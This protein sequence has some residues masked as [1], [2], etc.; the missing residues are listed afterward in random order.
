MYRALF[1]YDGQQGDRTLTFKSGDEFNLI[2]QINEHWW[3]MQSSTGE[4][5]LVPST[6]LAINK[7]V[8]SEIIESIERAI[9][10][11]HKSAAKRGGPLTA[12]ER[13]SL[14]K[15]I[16]HRQNVVDDKSVDGNENSAKSSSEISQLPLQTNYEKNGFKD[17]NTSPVKQESKDTIGEE[18]YVFMDLPDQP[19][20]QAPN[21]P[22]SIS[23]R[24]QS[25]SLRD[26]RKAP[27]PPSL[28][29]SSSETGK[30]N[31]ELQNSI[32]LGY[33]KGPIMEK[34][35]KD[36]V[37][38]LTVPNGL[39]MNIASKV[40]GRFNLDKKKSQK[41]VTCVLEGIMEG[42]PALS[43]LLQKVVGDLPQFPVEDIVFG[44]EDELRVILEDLSK[45]KD[46]SQQRSW[47][48]HE[49]YHIIEKLLTKLLKLLAGMDK[50]VSSKLLCEDDYHFLNDLVVYYQ[51][52]P[53]P[54]LR[55][56]LIQTFGCCCELGYDFVTQ[57]L[58]TVL[59]TELARELMEVKDITSFLNIA[60]LLTMLFSTGE[61]IP[62]HQ[63]A[64]FNEEFLEFVFDC[65]ERPHLDDKYDQIP[66]S[67]VSVLLSFNQHM[68]DPSENRV[69][70]V[71]SCRTDLKVFSEKLLLLVNREDDPVAIFD[72]HKPE[73]TSILKMMQDIFSQKETSNIFFTN[74]LM[75]LI[76]IILRQFTD[77]CPGDKVR[78]Q[79]LSLFYD[80]IT[81]SN[82]REH[83]HRCN[84]FGECFTSILVDEESEIEDDKYIV[85]NICSEFNT[86][87]PIFI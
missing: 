21:P 36:H 25:K 79:F 38:S 81:N 47:A 75:V 64:Q 48:L 29:R 77:R 31:K 30:N 53:R 56:L 39:G 24:T 22:R 23:G 44:P 3:Q 70:K 7:T 10:L 59:P 13:K 32:T 27:E 82:Y 86:L 15:L 34:C 68:K 17:P 28:S 49:D 61:A 73:P 80:I 14:Q 58:C 19:K 43:E 74:D 1:N 65:V 52:E 83:R 57:L 9:D 85:R 50:A 63:Y 62:L 5:G 6:Y 35:S 71:I 54:G 76:D 46:D 20:R 55:V 26:R 78:T 4:I 84:E 69:L 66:Y 33:N 72:Y 42:V 41:V 67:L 51:M 37:S 8:K 2:D 18:Q 12:E 60:L 87:F 40:M 11:I 45:R 16:S